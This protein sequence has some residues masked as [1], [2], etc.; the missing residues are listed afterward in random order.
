LNEQFFKVISDNVYI[1]LP[2]I[3]MGYNIKIW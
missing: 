1:D 2:D 3:K